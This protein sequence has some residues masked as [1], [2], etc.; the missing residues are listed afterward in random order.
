MNPSPRSSRRLRATQEDV[1]RATGVSRGLVSLAL[2]GGGRM[3]ETTRRRILEEARRLDYRTNTAAAELAS[4]RS[5][6]LAVVVP[7]LDNPF[8]DLVLR[9][10]RRRASQEGY[11]LA[12][13]VS[14]LADRLE[15]ST[16][17][18][19]LSLRPEGLILP[20]T[21]M[22][23]AAL[24]DLARLVPLVVMDR[25]LDS[26]VVSVVRLDEA[27]AAR[28]IVEHLAEQGLS[29][30]AYFS[31][32]PER[33]E[34]LA[35]ERRASLEL[36]A[37]HGGM[38]FAAYVC[39]GDAR[40]ALERASRDFAAPFG[41]VAY[42]DILALDLHSAILAE[43]LRAGSDLALVSYDNSPLAQRR[44]FSFS[45]IDQSVDLLA[46][47]SIVALLRPEDAPPVSVTVP[48]T[49]VVRSSSL[50]ITASEESERAAGVPPARI[51]PV[52]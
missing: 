50:M 12:A 26:G 30:I 28:Q 4:S 21:S 19:V 16:I 37:A 33:Y 5:R 10:L 44:E 46:A 3:S 14:D 1:A 49:L 34:P 20:G 48:A 36:A 38:E 22:S 6:R 47:E 29:S 17:D 15:A 40:H 25:T 7:Y 2:N 18:D 52:D 41:T 24:S 9:A 8:F 31:P 35:D 11:V 51:R 13:L 27:D 23:E 45:S 39:D 43:G 32:S 42:N